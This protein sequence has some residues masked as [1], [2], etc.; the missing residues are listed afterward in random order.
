M[1]GFTD[2]AEQKILDHFFTDPAWVPPATWYVGVSSTPILDDGTGA[3][4]PSGG[5]YARIATTA[6]DWSA[7]ASTA[8]AA[9]TNTANLSFPMATA[10]WLAGVSL[11][12]F[13]I[14][15]AATVGNVYCAGPLTI[16]RPIL[17]GDTATF[18]A[19][20]LVVRLGDSTDF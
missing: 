6:A 18:S 15:D 8:P 1:A 20:L 17:N 2:I 11:T 13:G 7:A 5:A 3:T 10:D 12:Y 4:E 9:K 14:W 16:A 19:G